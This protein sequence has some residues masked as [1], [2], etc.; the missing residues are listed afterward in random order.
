MT[1][2]IAQISDIHAARGAASLSALDQALDYLAMQKPDAII[3]SGDLANKPHAEGYAL[4]G[5]AL[6]AAWCPVFMVPGNADD[7]EAM[8]AGFPDAASW[9]AEGPLHVNEVVA[10]G[11]R[12]V[13]LD[14]TVPG[15]IYG[16]MTTDNLDFLAT[17]LDSEPIVPALIF[18]HQH[19]F[20][21]L[22][23]KLDK[24]MCRNVGPLSDVLRASRAKVLGVVCGHAHRAVSGM[25]GPVPAH[26]SPP[27]V[28]A[29]PAFVEGH[30]AAPVTDPPGLLLHAIDGDSLVTHTISL[31]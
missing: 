29:D 6:G 11:V 14:V 26:M 4:V 20:P 3:V 21:L 5:K 27:L 13:G 28:M 16:E 9:P 1:V 15:E 31:G 25:L 19:P 12:L 17:A 24:N 23:R 8:R 2:M 18:M 10:G 7:R 30:G 22:S